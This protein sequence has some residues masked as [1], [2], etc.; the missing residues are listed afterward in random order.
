[1]ERK[2]EELLRKLLPMFESEAQDHLKVISSGLIEIEQSQPEKQAGIVETVY[3]ECH[4]LK[5]AAR[6][7][8]LSRIVAICQ[9]MENVFSALKRKEIILSSN[10]L[11]ILHQAV[12]RVYRLVEAGEPSPA[13]RAGIGELVQKLDW[14]AQ[15]P[16]FSGEEAS[17]RIKPESI[18]QER[19]A[20]TAT[21]PAAASPPKHPATVLPSAE[22]VRIS[23]A[24]LDSL[25]LQAEEMLS[26][27]IAAEQRAEELREL[28]GALVQWKKERTRK[29]SF[30]KP[31]G[32]ARRGE[33]TTDDADAFFSFFKSR[34]TNLV[35]TAEFDRRSFGA[36]V[37]T[38]L[39]DTKKTLMLPFAS[40]LEIFPRLVRDLSREAG[41]EVDL[42]IS[43]TEIDLDRRVLEEIKDPL[44][45]LVRNCIDHGIERAADRKA[46]NKPPRGKLGI[47]ATPGNGRVEIAVS[48]DGAG[49]DV[50]GVKD[51]ALRSGVIS[52]EELDTLGENE[53]LNLVFCSGITTTPIITDL[54]GRG[55]GLAIVRERVERLNGRLSVETQ[56]DRGTSFRMVVPL[57]IATFRG[58]LVRVGE[59]LFFLPSAN[60]EKV[61][62]IRKEDIQTVEN[63]ETIPFDGGTI[64]F[65]KLGTVL[66]LQTN[67]IPQSEMPFVQVVIVGSTSKLF[68]FQ[69]DEI[70]RE[71]EV[72]LKKLGPQ[73]LC[74]RNISG[75]ALVGNGK[76]VPVLNVPDLIASAVKAVPIPSGVAPSRPP[77]LSS[78]LVVEDSITARALLKIILEAAGYIVTT[79]V[80]GID[81]LTALKTREFDLV[82]SD[83]EMPR[84]NGFDLT[85][86]IR[87]DKKLSEIPVVL[88]TALESREDKERGID[89]GANAYIVKSSFEQ[90]NLLE[91]VRRLI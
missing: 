83:I 82:V 79:A 45:H 61:A 62:R 39:D 55:L 53:S 6:S 81:A 56:P 40:L 75:A 7:V 17:E 5:G 42:S 91:V 38:L 30:R 71:Q 65:A 8:N 21:C 43:G 67:G 77:K 66:D 3:R 52:Q 31:T 85:Q 51:A 2:D 60:I 89:V 32:Q 50:A 44:T 86:K 68:A 35:K 70:V 73:L 9:S 84:M 19:Q 80:D 69:V 54:S 15:M 10:I 11:D 37:D 64:S 26:V 14:A 25:L 29:R 16:G 48:D 27:K 72:L 33:M 46:K 47:T 28:Y 36:M 90:S 34:L 57:T 12:D 20:G 24:K 58:V 49:I 18:D 63:R 88:V 23:T 13:E 78:I 59:H 22:T 76:V 41:K 4:S 74:V 87:A 1:M